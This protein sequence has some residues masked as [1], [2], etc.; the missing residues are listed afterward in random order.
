MKINEQ[1]IIVTGASRGLGR[2]MAKSL[3]EAGASVAYVANEGLVTDVA[4]EHDDTDGNTIGIEADVRRWDDVRAMVRHTEEHLGEVDVLINNA[5]TLQYRVNASHIQ[6][7]LWD[8]SVDAWETIL[9]TNLTGLFYCT[10]AVL[11]GMLDREHGRVVHIS[12][13]YGMQGR[14]SYAP[15][16]A[17]KFGLE[18]LHESLALEL[19]KEPGVSSVALRPPAGGIY[20]ESSE[21]IGHEPSDYACQDPEIM[22]NSIWRLVRGEGENGGRYQ[23]SQDGSELIEYGSLEEK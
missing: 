8:V 1:T 6:R 18:G 19:E 22:G 12:S 7:S 2:A 15:Y 17:S 10:K 4:A 9:K 3:T 14:Q 20:T 13:G 21:L 11:P 5:G 23:V 16:V